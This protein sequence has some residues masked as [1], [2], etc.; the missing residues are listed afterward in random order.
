M[1]I[2]QIEK[3]QKLINNSNSVIVVEGKKDKEA[4]KKIGASNIIDISGKSLENTIQMISFSK[5]ASVAILTDFDEEGKRQLGILTKNLHSQGI[6]VD[7]T[8]R[9]MIKMTF[10][11]QKIEELNF[12]TKFIDENL[13]ANYDKTT[14]KKKFLRQN[15]RKL[16]RSR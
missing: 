12:F 10:N 7:N 6:K 9:K 11:I 1:P 13:L 8:L 5:P 2:H 16:F 15:D 3:F 14:N 4:L